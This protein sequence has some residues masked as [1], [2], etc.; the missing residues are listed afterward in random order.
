[1]V[2]GGERCLDFSVREKPWLA[3]LLQCCSATLAGAD[4]EVEKKFRAVL[5]VPAEVAVFAQIDRRV[6]DSGQD[7]AVL[8]KVVSRRWIGGAVGQGPLH[9]KPGDEVFRAEDSGGG[10]PG[11]WCGSRR[12][13]AIVCSLILHCRSPLKVVLGIREVY[14]VLCHF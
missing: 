9:R 12:S 13:R 6:E 14:R 8:E 2:I 10:E 3:V 1:M 11:E 7:P 4:P 5:A